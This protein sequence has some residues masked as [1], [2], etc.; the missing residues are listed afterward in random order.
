MESAAPF[1]HIGTAPLTENSLADLLLF[2]PVSCFLFS[3]HVYRFAL[4]CIHLQ[5]NF[6]AIAFGM[7]VRV[8][9]WL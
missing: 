5:S 9:V 2:G 1:P 4:L 7:T 3:R 8:E 6:L